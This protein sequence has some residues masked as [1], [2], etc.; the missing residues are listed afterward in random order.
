MIHLKK[1]SNDSD[2]RLKVLITA[3]GYTGKCEIF[4][5]SLDELNTTIFGLDAVDELVNIVTLELVEPYVNRNI[6]PAQVQKLQIELKEA[7]LNF[8][9]VVEDEDGKY[10]RSTTL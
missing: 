2:F 3:D 5:E 10:V 1:I 8:Y 6:S 9:N 4:Q 7:M